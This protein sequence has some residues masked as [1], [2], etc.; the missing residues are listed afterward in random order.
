M[1]KKR[2]R[3]LSLMKKMAR[4]PPASFSSTRIGKKDMNYS[5]ALNSSS[6]VEHLGKC[7]SCE[8]LDKGLMQLQSLQSVQNHVALSGSG[9]YA[10]IHYTMEKTTKMAREITQ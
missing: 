10:Y 4:T 1:K 8:V 7:S 2:D 6:S 5:T 9:S 3:E